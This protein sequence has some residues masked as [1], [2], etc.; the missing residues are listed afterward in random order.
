MMTEPNPTDVF[1]RVMEHVTDGIEKARREI[2]R[3]DPNPL[4]SPEHALKMA[5]QDARQILMGV[6]AEIDAEIEKRTKN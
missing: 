4:S 2:A 1:D 6:V 3:L 5:L